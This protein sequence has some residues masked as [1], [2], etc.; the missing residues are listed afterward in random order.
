LLRATEVAN[1]AIPLRSHDLLPEHS[2]LA[3]AIVQVDWDQ[4]L[5]CVASFPFQR[6]FNLVFVPVR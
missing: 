3:K 2:L 6:L 4:V 1:N 5:G